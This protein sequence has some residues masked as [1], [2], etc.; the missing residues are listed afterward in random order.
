MH[1]RTLGR[2]GLSIS[3]IG[4]GAWAIGGTWWGDQGD[5]DSLS[6]LR[7]AIERGCNFIDTARVYG[8]GRSERLVGQVVRETKEDI[9]VATK[10]PPRD[11]QWPAKEGTPVARAFPK[12]HVISQCEASLKDLGMACVDLL[13]LHVWTDEWADGLD[14]WY[15]GMQTLKRQG[16]IRF[17]GVSIND[18]Q[19]ETALRAV[20]EGLVDTVQVIYNIFD[21][22]PQEELFPACR[23]HDVGVIVRVPFDEGSLTGKF[24][25]K[26]TFGEN[27]FRRGYFRGERLKETIERVRRLEPLLGDHA[28]TLAKLALKFCLAH[29][30]VST[31]IPGMRNGYQADLNT[32]ASD[33]APLPEEVLK[34][35]KDHRWTRNFYV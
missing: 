12:E 30:A 20:R 4:F 24:T 22:S 10:V 19:P 21:Q 1:Y 15:E 23:E 18:H 33:R 11:F 31:V 2:T 27:D 7:T 14:E 29:P 35:L 17:C 16:K 34:K 9:Y 5:E 8:N 3:E 6:A 13:Q 32:S 26:T 25:E 28:D